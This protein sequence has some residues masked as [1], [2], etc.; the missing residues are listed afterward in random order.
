MPEVPQHGQQR[1]ID[2]LG[3]A[4][5]P[6]GLGDDAEGGPRG[7]SLPTSRFHNAASFHLL[8]FLQQQ[9]QFDQLAAGAF[10]SVTVAAG[11]EFVLD[12]TTSVEKERR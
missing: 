7:W 12:P 2:G 8:L 10:H 5:A 1:A 9:Q 3:C 11:F 6:L 4:Q